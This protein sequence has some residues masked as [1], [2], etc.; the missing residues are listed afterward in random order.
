MEYSNYE[1]T[2]LLF[3]KVMPLRD[4]P[5]PLHADPTPHGHWQGS[6]CHKQIIDPAFRSLRPT[7]HKHFH[8][9]YFQTF[10][11]RKNTSNYLTTWHAA[12]EWPYGFQP[13]HNNA[14]FILP[15]TVVR[16][17]LFLALP[18]TW[19]TLQMTEGVG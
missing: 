19:W 1:M 12:H 9:R 15:N 6:K 4:W 8:T 17:T 7:I 16:N 13:F 5:S 2:S 3:L 14:P 10:K 11:S 18:K